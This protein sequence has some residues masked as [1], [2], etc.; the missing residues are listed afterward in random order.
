[1]RLTCNLTVEHRKIS[2]VNLVVRWVVPRQ[3]WPRAV[4]CPLTLSG[5]DRIRTPVHPVGPSAEIVQV[6][7]AFDARLAGGS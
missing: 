6:E 4:N 1:M 7:L 3:P 5:A 2:D